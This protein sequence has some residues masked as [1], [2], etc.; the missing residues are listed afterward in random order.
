MS[1]ASVSPDSAADQANAW[2]AEHYQELR[3][4]AR[5]QFAGFDADRCEECACEALAMVAAS[6]HSAARRGTLHRLSPSTCIYYSTRQ[7]KGGRKAAGYSSTDAL[8]EATKLKRGIHVIPLDQELDLGSDKPVSLHE[9]LADRDAEQPI[10]VVR[11]QHDLGL[12]LSSDSVSC[13]GRQVF[14]ALAKSAGK[15]KQKELAF[16]LGITAARLTQIKGE[17]AST[18]ATF[19]YAGPLGQRPIHV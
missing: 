14:L 3:D 2:L 6:V 9:A 17:L 19:G 10:E 7:I 16:D 18:L 12:A 8:S 1:T 4:R 11:R 5:V 15:V 13:K